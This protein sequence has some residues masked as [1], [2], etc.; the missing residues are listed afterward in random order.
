MSRERELLKKIMAYMCAEY[1]VITEFEMIAQIEDTVKEIQ[2]LLAQPDREPL[3]QDRLA[4][5]YAL[6]VLYDPLVFARQV[7]LAHGIDWS[8]DE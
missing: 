1:L 6:N 7:E 8:R 2:N 5:L 4:Q 3:S